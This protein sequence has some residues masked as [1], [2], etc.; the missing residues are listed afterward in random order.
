MALVL[1]P[2]ELGGE[3]SAWASAVVGVEGGSATPPPPVVVVASA[4]V[5]VLAP[6]KRSSSE[7]PAA[8]VGVECMVESPSA[9]ACACGACG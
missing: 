5:V 8:E 2:C 6:G 1:A 3:S 9:S 7:S 4:A